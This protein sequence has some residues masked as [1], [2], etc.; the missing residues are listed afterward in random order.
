MLKY[1]A[2]RLL[3]AIP[4]LF[5]I[6]LI[7]FAISRNV[8]GDPIFL[9][10]DAQ[11]REGRNISPE[12]RNQEYA[13]LSHEKGLDLP[14]F[15]L[16]MSSMAEPDT[17]HRI[18]FM[19]DRKNLAEMVNLYGDWPQIETYYHS[20][21]TALK[22]LRRIK[23]EPAY[24]AYL[25]DAQHTVEELKTVPTPS[26]IHY[27]LDALDSLV[28]LSPILH[29][30][31]Q[32]E[33]TAIRQAFAAVEANAST[34]K[35]Y[36][37]TFHWYGMDNQFHVWLK[38]LWHLD[39]GKSYNNRR[40]VGT[41]ISE[42]M[43]WTVFMGFF[44]FVIAYCIAIPVGVFSVRRR[45][46]WQDRVVTV[47]LFMLHSVPTF[48]TAMLVMTFLCNPDY[49]QLFPTTGIS[50][51]G[52]EQWPWSY[53]LLDYAYHLTLP[54]LIFSYHGISF[55][56]RQMRG[57][58]IDTIHA[59]YIRT[60]RAKGLPE[61]IVV[62]RHA[63]RNSLLPIITHVS[64][65]FPAMVSGAI[66]TEFIFSVPGMGLLTLDALGSYDHPVV[67]AIFAITAIATL[68]GILVADILYAL[69]DPRISFSDR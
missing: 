69:A 34:W 25:L 61:K 1:I 7:T 54:T 65:L 40:P 57:G 28:A 59:D 3:V 45:N 51:D 19:G 5:A 8:P 52:A 50:S 42:A 67:L 44:S 47:A 46:H 63:L 4:T 49:L 9:E 68:L 41:M 12:R 13:R 38:A 23:F 33:A 43:P 56:S 20:L 26:E 66:V 21:E 48:V 30:S 16:G 60:A 31:V 10:M 58:M 62:W 39:F 55:I 2:R 53:R 17:L 64:G 35:L 27:R 14:L 32:A 36:V 29:D 18:M 37:P 22:Q 6:L 11:F 24:K 15:Y